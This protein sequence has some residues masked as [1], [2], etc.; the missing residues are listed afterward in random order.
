[1][2]IEHTRRVLGEQRGPEIQNGSRSGHGG[3]ENSHR[4]PPDL[5]FP[6]Y[7]TGER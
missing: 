3:T 6:S 7:R 4:P 1:M 5:S 2:Q